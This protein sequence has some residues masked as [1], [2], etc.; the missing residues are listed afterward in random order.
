MPPTKILSKEEAIALT[1]GPYSQIFAE[2]IAGSIA[3]FLWCEPD[4]YGGLKARN[5][6]A[7][8]VSGDRT[9]LVTADHVFT[10]Y[11][12]ARE[13]FGAVTRC[14]IGNIAFNPEQRLIARSLSLDIAT[15]EISPEEIKRTHSHRW[16]MTFDPM[17]PERGKGVLF[18][19]F[20]R[21][22]R[23]N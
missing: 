6:T 9:F 18:A 7:F 10:G 13:K 17:V 22:A 21:L 1:R 14:R 20:P 11:L 5:G 3:P 12:E 8:F 16:A 19:G 23:I 4:G 15:F 2:T